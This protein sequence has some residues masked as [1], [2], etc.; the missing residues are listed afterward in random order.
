MQHSTTDGRAV[1]RFSRSRTAFCR[2]PL[3][4]ADVWT[5]QI[6][7]I[8]VCRCNSR[9]RTALYMPDLQ[10]LVRNPLRSVNGGLFYTCG[11]TNVGAAFGD[12]YF[13]GRVRLI[14]AEQAYA[15]AEWEGDE[16][17]L[18]CGGVM[19]Q[20]GVCYENLSLTRN[21]ET[22][23]GSDE[24]CV[25]DTVCNDGFS[26]GPLYDDVSCGVRVPAVKRW[27]AFVCGGG[28]G[29]RGLLLYGTRCSGNPT[30]AAVFLQRNVTKMG[31]GCIVCTILRCLLVY[32]CDS[33]R[34]A[35]RI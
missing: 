32:R 3:W 5:S 1:R 17:F 15:C 16:Y 33:M 34:A 9:E 7:H 21:I 31:W 13:H 29:K 23:L 10:S 30:T 4:R 8:A 14:P 35:C 18:R 11:L 19:R 26:R 6:L 27:R 24:I 25:S 20:N 28:Y 2:Q 12:D 22:A